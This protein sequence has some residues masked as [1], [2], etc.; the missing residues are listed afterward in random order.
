MQE[1]RMSLSSKDLLWLSRVP[2]EWAGRCFWVLVTLPW[3][4]HLVLQLC[5]NPWICFCH[6]CSW[7][8]F[9]V[10]TLTSPWT[11]SE[12]PS[13]AVW[14]KLQHSF[15]FTHVSCLSEIRRI[16]GSKL[17]YGDFKLRAASHEHSRVWT[18]HGFSLHG[19]ENKCH[20][21]FGF[22]PE[23]LT[24]LG[25]STGRVGAVVLLCWSFMEY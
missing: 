14:Q 12:T 10:L 6:T 20:I 15:N 19:A 9:R 5:Q 2:R 11:R 25:T 21:V 24:I 13:A 4:T 7:L 18:A 17:A 16:L 1:L 22:H 8:Q 3:G 23:Q